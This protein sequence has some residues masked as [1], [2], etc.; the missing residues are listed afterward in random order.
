MSTELVFDD[1]P[2]D[3]APPTVDDSGK[4]EPDPH[5]IDAANQGRLRMADLSLA[6]R[7]WVVAGLQAGGLTAGETAMRLRCSLRLI[8]TI[9]ADP[10][11]SVCLFAMEQSVVMA[12]ACAQLQRQVADAQRQT[13]VE[14]QRLNTMKAERDRLVDTLAGRKPAAVR[15]GD[16]LIVP[17]RTIRY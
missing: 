8:R 15:P 14:A 10:M 1:E 4:W 17:G 7:S 2:N 12:A 3:D 11:T 5:L 13:F 6:D 16:R 9:R